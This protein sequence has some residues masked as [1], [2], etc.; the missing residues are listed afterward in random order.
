MNKLYLAKVENKNIERIQEIYG[1]IEM[2]D[3]NIG[4]KYLSPIVFRDTDPI[5]GNDL[6]IEEVSEAN[7]RHKHFG[8]QGAEILNDNQ[9][10]SQD[11][12]NAPPRI[13]DHIACLDY[14]FVELQEV[15]GSDD[16]IALAARTSYATGKRKSGQKT[17]LR[18]LLR[19]LHTTPFETSSLKLRIYLP[20]V[21]YRQL[22]RHRTA[23]QLEPSGYSAFDSNDTAFQ[24]Y[25][26]QNEMSGR[27]VELPDHYYIPEIE[28]ID[29]QS[30]S[31]KQGTEVGEFTWFQKDEMR[32]IMER[33]V[34]QA[35]KTYEEK[36]EA[37]VARETA[38]NN[39]PLTQYTLLIWKID[40][41]NLLHFLS[42][43]LHSH[44]Q[45]EVRQYALAIYEF[46]KSYFPETASAFEDYHLGSKRFS[47]T[48]S[49]ALEFAIAG[50]EGRK[51]A[52]NRF[53]ELVKNQ[54]E[55]KEFAEKI[56][57]DVD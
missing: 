20:I 6:S 22:F 31:N 51:N 3:K 17:L 37:G 47:E 46:V 48:E 27:Y 32:K 30:K 2:P 9:I 11:V 36:L 52:Y 44:A 50:E 43:R 24:K 38:R 25:S 13:N 23:V 21:V 1:N 4:A 54:R 35:R 57:Y 49:E 7:R 18:Y 15:G 56:G 29:G 33:E 5:D 16:D 14:G 28:R 19:N 41:K 34:A 53:C 40:L 8:L 45:W 39:L 26:V 10:S 55:R 42:L 12:F